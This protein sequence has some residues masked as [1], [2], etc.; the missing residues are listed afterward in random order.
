MT[1]NHLLL[2]KDIY[3]S[4]QTYRSIELHLFCDGRLKG[5]PRLR[6]FRSNKHLIEDTE[7]HTLVS[8]STMQKPISEECDYS[9]GLTPELVL[10]YPLNFVTVNGNL[11]MWK[12]LKS[13]SSKDDRRNHCKVMLGKRNNKGGV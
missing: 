12:D 11:L 5:Q 10:P 7:M 2:C 9:S 6:V 4:F 8:A 1:S 3:S 13:G